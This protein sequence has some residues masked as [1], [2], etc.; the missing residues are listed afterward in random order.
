MELKKRERVWQKVLITF[1]TPTLA[2]F[3]TGLLISRSG[4]LQP[5]GVWLEKPDTGNVITTNQITLKFSAYSYTSL[6]LEKVE[7]LYWYEGINQHAWNKLC[8]FQPRDDRTYTCNFD[9]AQ[10]KV[11]VGKKILVSFNVYGVLTRESAIGSMLV[12]Y[13]FAPDGWSCFYWQQKDVS[14]PCEAR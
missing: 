7:G 8:V 3:F 6:P 11:P 5:G 9:F 2:I 13:K 1:L 14:N 12:N 4:M 10:L